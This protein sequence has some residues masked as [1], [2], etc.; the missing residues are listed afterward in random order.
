[1]FRMEQIGRALSDPI[2]KEVQVIS[3]ILP[4]QYN[5]ILL[6]RFKDLCET[7]FSCFDTWDDEKI[8]RQAVRLYGKK[9]SGRDK[10]VR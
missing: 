6:K 9:L 2:Y 7:V 1:M 4:T 5:L 10:F 8:D 3:L